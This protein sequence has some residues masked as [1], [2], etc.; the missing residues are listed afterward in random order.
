MKRFAT[1]AITSLL[2]VL[3]VQ[4]ASADSFSIGRFT[5]AASEQKTVTLHLNGTRSYIAFQMDLY[6]PQGITIAT[7]SRG[8][9]LM[10]VNMDMQEEAGDH[11]VTGNK[12]TDIEG[13][14]RL[15]VESSE[16]YAFA[17]QSGDVLDITLKASDAVTTGEQMIQLTQQVLNDEARNEITFTDASIPFDVAI[18]VN[19]SALGYASFSWPY[20]LDFSGQEVEA[21][22]AKEHSEGVLHMES[23]IKVPANTGIVLKGNQGTYHPQTTTAITDDV[24]G[25]LLLGT[26]NGPL[27]VT[28]SDIFVLSDLSNG[29]AGFYRAAENL[30]I[31]QYKAYLQTTAQVREFVFDDDPTGMRTIRAK[32]AEDYFTVEGVRIDQPQR[33]GLYIS[34]GRKLIVK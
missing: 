14:Y 24:T 26:A 27:T 13:H 10:S 7:N 21:F 11:T 30:V 8:K 17:K 12:L 23:V 1:W 18:D 19:V 9:M 3:A 2:T 25:N 5:I 33:K 34:G 15:M 28:G 4:Q 6:L 20:A 16:N 22:I 29:R 31:P 32:Q